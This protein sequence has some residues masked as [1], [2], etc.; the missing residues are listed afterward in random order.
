MSSN[1]YTKF[2]SS[3]NCVE[4][5]KFHIC[6]GN[7]RILPIWKTDSNDAF[8]FKTVW[9]NC[10]I[11]G[12]KVP[13]ISYSGPSFRISDNIGHQ[14]HIFVLLNWI[15]APEC[16][17]EDT[18]S[19]RNVRFLFIYNSKNFTNYWD[20]VIN[21]EHHTLNNLPLLNVSFL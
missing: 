4:K 13:L 16:E 10:C 7:L 18:S 2:V 3:S 6:A 5:S 1:K 19:S 21:R 15:Q 12:M 9:L 20:P 17:L 11:F 14:H 8:K